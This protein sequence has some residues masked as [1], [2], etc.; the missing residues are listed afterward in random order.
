MTATMTN[1]ETRDQVCPYCGARPLVQSAEYISSTCM[2]SYCQEAAFKAGVIWSALSR[3]TKLA[4]AER[5]PR[6]LDR[7]LGASARNVID[8]VLARCDK[9]AAEARR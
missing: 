3:K 5:D 1:N 8:V 6:T 4:L 7:Q 9:Y 2:D